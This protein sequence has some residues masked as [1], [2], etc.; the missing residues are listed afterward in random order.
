M[1][2]YLA[3]IVKIRGAICPLSTS[4][5]SLKWRQRPSFDKRCRYVFNYSSMTSNIILAPSLK[6]FWKI[7]QSVLVWCSRTQSVYFS[8]SSFCSF[9]IVAL[10]FSSF[11]QISSSNFLYSLQEDVS[12]SVGS[13]LP[14]QNSSRILIRHPPRRSSHAGQFLLHDCGCCLWLQPMP[15]NRAASC[16]LSH[17]QMPSSARW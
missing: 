10:S 3:V 8:N 9:V 13:T 2:A 17:P 1:I 7:K 5:Y 4:L 16:A 11:R 12:Y 14:Y 15:S 6:P